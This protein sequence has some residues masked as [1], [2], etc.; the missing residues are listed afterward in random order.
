LDVVT[1]LQEVPAVARQL[2]GEAKGRLAGQKALEH[3]HDLGTGVPNAFEERACKQVE[4]ASAF[5]AS[6]VQNRR[7]IPHVWRLM[8]R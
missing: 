3:E 7:P 6:V 2:F 5:L 4:H 1:P 8:A